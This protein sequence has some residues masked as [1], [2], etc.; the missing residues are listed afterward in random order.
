V[1]R[2]CSIRVPFTRPLYDPLLEPGQWLPLRF[3]LDMSRVQNC[4]C[5]LL[6]SFQENVGIVP[7][8]GYECFISNVL[9]LRNTLIIP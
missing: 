7:E 3:L 6:Q 1:K 5:G 2:A 9:Q 4:F 8:L